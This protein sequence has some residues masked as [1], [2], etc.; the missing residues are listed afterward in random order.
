MKQLTKLLTNDRGC[1]AVVSSDGHVVT[2]G[3]SYKKH[4]VIH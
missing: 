1:Y 4:Q 3:H 2:V